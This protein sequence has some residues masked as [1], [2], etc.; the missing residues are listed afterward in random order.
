LK[1]IIL[2]IGVILGTV[3]LVVGGMAIGHGDRTGWLYLLLALF[4]FVL[5][6]A[7]GQ[8]F[9]DIVRRGPDA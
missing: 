9:R 6:A 3:G 8:R 4:C 1:N 7:L 5:A 2:F